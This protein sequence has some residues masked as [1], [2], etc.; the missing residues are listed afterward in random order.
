MTC[1]GVLVFV[2]VLCCLIIL[3][4]LQQAMEDLNM[5]FVQW[6]WFC[7]IP[8][9]KSFDSPTKRRVVLGCHDVKNNF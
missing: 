4:S 6:F 2:R 7:Y 9:A 8:R 5:L 1:Y 3:V